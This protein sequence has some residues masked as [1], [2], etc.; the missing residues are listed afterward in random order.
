MSLKKQ[1][2]IYRERERCFQTGGW[3]PATDQHWV[4]RCHLV[5]KPGQNN[6]RVVI[7]F[8]HLNRFMVEKGCRYET[9]KALRNLT[10]TGDFYCSIDLK[11]GYHAVA[12]HPDDRKY[13]TFDL[14]PPP[15]GVGGPR[16][17]QASALSFGWSHSPFIF[18]KVMRVL[19]R[20]LRSRGI[21]VLPYLDDFLLISRSHS[22]ALRDRDILQTLLHNLGLKRNE[23]KGQ[24]E[25]QQTVDH[26]GLS[27]DSQRGLF[28]V[29]PAKVTK[30]QKAAKEMIIRA[31]SNCRWVHSRALASFSGLVLSVHLACPLARYRTRAL[32]DSL[33]ARNGWSGSVQLSG[34]AL[35]DLSWWASLD[36]HCGAT[37]RALWIPATT[38]VLHTD[39]AKSDW[40]AYLNTTTPARGFFSPEER[41][42]HIT[43]KELIAVRMAV[44]SFGPQLAGH[45]V[46]HWEDNQAVVRIITNMVSKAPAMMRE[47]RRLQAALAKWDIHLQSHY[48][49]SADNPADRLTRWK[50]DR[51]DWKLNPVLFRSAV[52]RWGQMPTIDR[53]AT[54]SNR[55]V[56]R[57][58][59][60]FHSPGCEAVDAFTQQWKGEL[61]W[62]NPPWDELS[63]VLQTL[64]ESGAAAYLVVPE[65]PSQPWWPD[66]LELTTDSFLVAPARD[67]FLPGHL[68]SVEAMG[69][70]FWYTRVCKIG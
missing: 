29:P 2:F 27:V 66:L 46:L 59:S 31:K 21:R 65:W 64:R 55:Q 56:S 51:S 8:R 10:R 14:G 50:R 17:V 45:H 37:Q 35:R 44:E 49:R 34:L 4:S 69:S 61:N 60:R 41:L 30:I 6:Y 23:S 32:F 70:P 67:N 54:P 68:G 16:F 1:K 15:P 62:L 57:F 13:F 5:P 9:L 58:N 52:R 42:G 38:Q 19:V 63:R 33:S 24:W 36:S 47:L 26:L 43:L 7:D 25:P 28:L 48:I 53:F 18:T 22:D 20:A 12:V 11:D 40:G 3:E 39:A